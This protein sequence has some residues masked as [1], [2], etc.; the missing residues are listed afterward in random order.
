MAPPETRAILSLGKAAPIP[1]LSAIDASFV[2]V[3]DYT[4]RKLE[5]A[6]TLTAGWEMQSLSIMLTTQS[7]TDRLLKARREPL[8]T[9]RMT[10]RALYD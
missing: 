3:L 9:A 4:V 6:R 1:S 8:H 7:L 5:E 2:C 10:D